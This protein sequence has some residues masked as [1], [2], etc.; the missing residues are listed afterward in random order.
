M[1]RIRPAFLPPL[2]WLSWF[3]ELNVRTYVHDE[4]GLPGVW[5]YSL[6]CNQPLAV[7]LARRCFRLPYFHARMTA[8]RSGGVIDYCCARRGSREARYR[9][10]AAAD[11]RTAT[12]GSLEFFLLERYVLFTTDAAGGIYCGRVHHEP[13]RFGATEVESLSAEPARLAGFDLK[14]EPCSLLAA[15]HVDVQI[16]KL[17]GVPA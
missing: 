15:K 6:D 17:Q 7:Q 16:F 5:F 8:R 4:Q 11:T 13:Y 10:T 9:W 1:E 12:P 2:P 14:G 3:L